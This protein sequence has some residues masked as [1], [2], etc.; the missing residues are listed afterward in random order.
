MRSIKRLTILLAAT[1]LTFLLFLPVAAQG[2]IYLPASVPSFNQ[3]YRGEGGYWGDCGMGTN[4]CPDTIGTAGCLITSFSMVLGYYDVNLSIPRE[5]SCTD[6]ARTGMDPG[7]LNDWL[8]THGGYG[9]CEGDI[10]SCCLEWTHLPPQISITQYVNHSEQGVDG[11]TQ[12]RIDD[13][14]SAGYP[15]ISGVHWGSHCHGSMTQKEDCHWVVITGKK[16]ST[17]MIIDPYNRDKSDSSGV[18]TTLDRGTFGSYTIDRY[19]I[20]K[21]IVPSARLADLHLSLSFSP[22]GRVRAGVSQVRSISI[23]GARPDAPVV[24]YVRV[25]DPHG[26]VRYAQYGSDT[27]IHYTQ[28]RRSFYA[29][30]RSFSDGTYVLSETS[31]AG[32]EAG[33]WTWEAWAEDPAHLGRP[34]GYDVAS[35]T[36]TASNPG[37]GSGIAIALTLAIFIASL[38]YV[39]M[40]LRTGN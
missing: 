25:T 3:A 14:L 24:L 36:I 12:Q 1:T 30:P 11:T 8:K 22:S 20:V 40:L 6:T 31:T 38:I 23:T 19:V 28:E 27:L 32:E 5:Y 26:D 39:S 13:A 7:I 10:G 34:Y 37:A 2:D 9:K 29:Q 17:Y 18:S 33:T 21:G 16:G 15:V 35:Y 4:G